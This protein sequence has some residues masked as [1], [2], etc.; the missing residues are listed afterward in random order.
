M[1]L[2]SI[3]RR[4]FLKK[5]SKGLAGAAL[6]TLAT[7]S[8]YCNKQQKETPAILGGTPVRSKPFPSWPM[9]DDTDVKMYLDA[10]HDKAW[11]KLNGDKVTEFENKWA[12]LNGVPHCVTTNGGTMALYTSLSALGIGPGDEVLVSTYTFVA[13]MN[14]IPV[15]FAL[16]VFVD[17]DPETLKMDANKIEERITKN[18]RAIIP[19]HIGGGACDMDRI[20]AIAKK[21]NLAVVEDACQAWLGEW[22]NKKLGSIGDTGCFSFQVTKNIP[23]GEGGA[24]IGSNEELMQLCSSFTNNGRG[25][26]SAGA[27]LF[28]NPYPGLNHRM[29]EF[30]GA[31]LLGQ[32]RRLEEQQKLRNDNGD[33]LDSLLNN[34][35][36]VSPVKKYPGQTRHGY[37]LYMMLYD[38]T[39]FNGLPRNKFVEAIIKEGIPMSTGYT[40][41]NKFSLVEYHLNSRGFKS[42]F[43]KQRLDK[44]RKENQCPVNDKLCEDVGMWMGQTVL[45]GTKN[46]MDSI[47]EA[48]AKIKKHS[49]KLI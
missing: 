15:L 39:Q 47:A 2:K 33:Y 36:G 24:I 7:T 25:P 34:I 6:A 21:H 1:N 16:P 10:F 41:L 4:T 26:K 8:I 20:M 9:Y 27:S 44:Y 38:R 31:I 22:N 11:C 32:L 19:V 29:T 18:T 23:S 35:P 13:S 46:D 3:T 30:Q 49:A 14:V 12:A 17:T 37:H 42:V 45:L 40:Q 43:S 28:G 5:T 48:V